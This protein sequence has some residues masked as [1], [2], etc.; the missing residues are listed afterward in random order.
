MAWMRSGVRSPSAPLLDF[1][2]IPEA[3]ARPVRLVPDTPAERRPILQLGGRWQ[4]SWPPGA[5]SRRI[6]ESALARPRGSEAANGSAH[7]FLCP[8]RRRRPRGPG[9]RLV[10]RVR[11]AEPPA[12]RLARGRAGQHRSDGDE[13]HAAEEDGSLD[14]HGLDGHGFGLGRLH[15]AC[16][17]TVVHSGCERSCSDQH[18]LDGGDA[19]RLLPVLRRRQ[20]QRDAVS[21]Q[22]VG[23]VPVRGA[24][25]V[26]GRVLVAVLRGAGGS[27]GWFVR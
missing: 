5:V 19:G 4:A 10:A 27:P 15:S 13:D 25:C 3:F 14:G 7:A 11:G 2:R 12:G 20:S 18:M 6:R 8:R 24:R 9:G 16:Q 17:H 26:R 23:Q 22:R 1:S 21:R